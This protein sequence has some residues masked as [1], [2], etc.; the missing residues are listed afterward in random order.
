MFHTLTPR[1]HRLSPLILLVAVCAL[2]LGAFGDSARGT[3]PSEAHLT[4]SAPLPPTAPTSD[5]IGLERLDGDSGAGGPSPAAP[6]AVA[7]QSESVSAVVVSFCPWRAQDALA[8]AGR[9][10]APSTAP[11]VSRV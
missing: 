3:A 11:P 9:F 5:A 4:T 10:T 6:A 7:A 8:R 2:Q 1:P